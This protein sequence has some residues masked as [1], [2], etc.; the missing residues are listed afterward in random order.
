MLVGKKII[1]YCALAL[2]TLMLSACNK[3]TQLFCQS[4]EK[5]YHVIMFESSIGEPY[6]YVNGNES[7]LG[8]AISNGVP[9]TT[10]NI[11]YEIYKSGRGF[12]Q[13]IRASICGHI[14]PAN[15]HFGEYY[16]NKEMMI[17]QIVIEEKIDVT[18]LNRRN[19]FLP[20]K[21]SH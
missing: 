20:P 15:S 16:V 5:Q 9:R 2:T 10:Y 13:G 19:T 18:K 8:Y 12:D 21:F 11:M 7:R 6:I 3:N 14:V 4:P 1:I 17:S